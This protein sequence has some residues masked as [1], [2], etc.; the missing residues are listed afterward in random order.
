M[1]KLWINLENMW[2]M[3]LGVFAL[4]LYVIFNDRLE[5][6]VGCKMMNAICTSE[7]ISRVLN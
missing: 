3:P 7:S 4:K 1:M 2:S 6:H 5:Y